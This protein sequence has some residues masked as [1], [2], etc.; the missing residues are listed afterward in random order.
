MGMIDTNSKKFSGAMVIFW[1]AVFILCFGAL[2]YNVFR[3]KNP[4]PEVPKVPEKVEEPAKNYVEQTVFNFRE[5]PRWTV[6]MEEF[7][8]KGHS[9]ISLNN[10]PILHAQHCVCLTTNK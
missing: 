9:Y 5:H 2:T 1:A 8:Y 4:V 3:T 10:K 7:Q 6:I